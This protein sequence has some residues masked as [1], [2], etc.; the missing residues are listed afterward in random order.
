MSL[1]QSVISEILANRSACLVVWRLGLHLV[2][3][4]LAY[5]H[6]CSTDNILAGR[7]K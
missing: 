2:F 3:L 6:M 1:E 7:I 4:Q 5:D